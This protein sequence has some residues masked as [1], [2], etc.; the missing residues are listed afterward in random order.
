V[1]T[2][3]IGGLIAAEGEQAVIVELLQRLW[4]TEALDIVG[5]GVD[6]GGNAP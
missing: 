2:Q 4:L 5:R 6:V 1:H 3:Q